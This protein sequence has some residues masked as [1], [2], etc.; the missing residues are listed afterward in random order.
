MALTEKTIT[1]AEKGERERVIWDGDISGFGLRVQPSG[2]KS[3]VL[4]Y[5]TAGGRRGRVRKVTI[6]KLGS[7]WTLEKAR[8]EAKRLLAVV[9]LGGDPAKDKRDI[10]EAPTVAELCDLYFEEGCAT[11]KASTV[12]VDKGRVE[13]HIKP[14][15]GH[16]RVAEVTRADIERFLGDV[17]A[18]KTA[19]DV[20][21]TKKRGRAIVTG[22]RGTATRAAGLLGGIFTFAVNRRIRPD[23]PVRGV[24]RFPDQRGERYLSADDWSKLGS[25]LRL[26]ADAGV[27]PTGLAIIRLLALTGAR[28]SELVNLRWSE[29]DF[30][31]SRLL[32]GDSK[33]GA[34]PITLGAPALQFL[35]EHDAKR[36]ESE[37]RGEWVFEGERGA[38]PFGGLPRVWR[39]V[40][41]LADLPTLRLHDLRHGFAS[42]GIAAGAGLPVIGAL[43]GHRDVK[44]TSRYAHLADN[45]VQRA[46]TKISRG[47][48][49][50][51]D[52]TPKRVNA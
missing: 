20:K 13:R 11:K 36:P 43:L 25:G 52:A 31:N 27:N 2:A 14:R 1:D 47:I 5:R 41:A 8:R 23:N 6:G 46:A 17:A 26:A 50:S 40:R 19:A 3:F 49:R 30:Q 15:L 4:M 21:T 33:T 35:S 12:S 22:G 42:H 18:G 28:K 32:L 10:R 24:K 48:D 44:T 16:L 38:G 37:E 45:P 7:P 39:T 51:L 34:K 29:V 9:E